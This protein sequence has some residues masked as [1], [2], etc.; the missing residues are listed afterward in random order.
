EDR[1]VVADQ[2]VVA[3]VG[4]E[5]ERE[6]AYVAPGIGTARL[7]CHGR[8]AREHLGFTALLEYG[9]LGISGD[10]CSGL[11]R[12]E[13][14]RAFGMRLAFRHFFPI[15]VRHLLQKVNVMKQNGAIRAG[16]QRIAVAWRGGPGAHG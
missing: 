13:S 5:L 1:R 4:I 3:F 12:A 10:I 7:A 2:I 16:R 14:S 11:E 15:E 8:E 6:A 9:S